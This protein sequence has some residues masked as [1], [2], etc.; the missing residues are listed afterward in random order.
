[1][2]YLSCRKDVV[3]YLRNCVV[4]Y[5]R[6]AWKLAGMMA[7]SWKIG[8]VNFVVKMFQRKSFI[9]CVPVTYIVTFMILYTNIISAYPKFQDLASNE[10]FIYKLENCLIPA[11]KCAQTTF[12]RHRNSLWLQWRHN[13]RDGISNHRRLDGLHN[14]L[15]RCIIIYQR[16]HQS[17]ASLAFVRKIYRWPVNSPHKGPCSY[18]ENISIWWRH[19]V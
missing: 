3:L 17:S 10:K 16:K 14:R 6:Y 8:H 19:H 5:Y 9:S 18:T 2:C 15:F 12:D 4:E 13:E 1:M 11:A 7:S